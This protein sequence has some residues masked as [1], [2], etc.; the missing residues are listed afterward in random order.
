MTN[1]EVKN[2]LKEMTVEIPEEE[3]K[4]SRGW[5]RSWDKTGILNFCSEIVG[6]G[7]KYYPINAEKFYNLFRLDGGVEVIRNPVYFSGQMVKWA[8]TQL[9]KEVVIKT[10][11]NKHRD[12][13]GAIGVFLR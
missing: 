8:F 12:K 5:T 13:T 6:S 2:L 10:K 3:F 9:K 7:V 1:K 11:N 4:K